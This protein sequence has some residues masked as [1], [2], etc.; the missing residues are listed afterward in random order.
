MMHNKCYKL[1]DNWFTIG[2]CFVPILLYSILQHIYVV[3]YKNG[4]ELKKREKKE[5]ENV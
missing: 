4:K 1:H 5:E 3:T 2:I